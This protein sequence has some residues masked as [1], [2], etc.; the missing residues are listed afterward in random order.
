MSER[1]KIAPTETIVD[2]KMSRLSRATARHRGPL[3]W[4][5]LPLMILEVLLSVL[6][7]GL[8]L[9]LFRYLLLLVAQTGFHFVVMPALVCLSCWPSVAASFTMLVGS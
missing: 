7:L 2:S 3:K 4:L 8:F 9:R 6:V 1:T 5:A